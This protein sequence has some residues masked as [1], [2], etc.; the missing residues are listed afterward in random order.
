MQGQ[1]SRASFHD[2][3]AVPQFRALW[4][5]QVLSTAGDQ[6][7]RVA[8]TLLVYDRTQSALL[9]AVTFVMG[10]LPAFIGGTLLSGLGDP[11]PRRAVMVGCDLA[12]AALVVV[13]TLP[14][15]PL[16]V[17]VALLFAVTA[18]NA[19]FTS[20]RSAV[21]PEILT[22][23][24]YVVATAVTLTTS[25]FA[26][27][28]G[29]AAGGVIA[30]AFG[31]R[32]SL[33]ADAATFA[34]SALLIRLGIAANPAPPRA[35]PAVRAG[36]FAALAAGRGWCSRPRRCGRRCCS[37]GSL[38]PTTPPKAWPRPSPMTSAAARPRPACCWP[39]RLSATPSALSP[40]AG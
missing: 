20:A 34:A 11:L 36:P 31:T 23:D 25:Q 15:L 16:A 29:F 5:A 32:P 17:L 2:V 3:F 33:L 6:I 9:A 18:G 4:L 38:P 13:M 14:R 39:P 10:M 19:P 8:L 40:S 26:Q 12:W 27:V 24:R 1:A 22:G 7:A 37:P 35:G 28:A 30:A 21:Y